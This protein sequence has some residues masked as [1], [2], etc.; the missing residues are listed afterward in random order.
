M[1]FPSG[2]GTIHDPMASFFQNRASSLP[3]GVG[4]IVYVYPFPDGPLTERF[5]HPAFSKRRMS[6][7]WPL[8][9]LASHPF[10]SS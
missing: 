4:V 1:C 7:M 2:V 8:D 6:S 9:A 5:T 3:L 10:V